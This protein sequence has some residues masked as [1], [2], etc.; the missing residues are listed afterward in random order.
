MIFSSLA[1]I[2]FVAGSVS[3]LPAHYE[4]SSRRSG[5]TL[6]SAGCGSASAWYFDANNHANVT[7]VDRSFLVHIPAAYDMNTPHAVVLS[8]HGFKQDDLE[9]EK[10]SGFSERGLKLNGKVRA[11]RSLADSVINHSSY[12]QGIIGGRDQLKLVYPPSLPNG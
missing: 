4:H 7:I 11:D 10:I 8:F 1:T 5:D 2:L 9:Q 6:A 3:G 12:L